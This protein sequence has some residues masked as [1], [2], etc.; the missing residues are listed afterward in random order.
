MTSP[1]R[2]NILVLCTGNSA[3]SIMAEALFGGAPGSPFRA[4]SAG[5]QPTGQPNPFAVEQ[6]KRHGLDLA[7][8]SKSWDEFV[9]A[10]APTLD[11]VVTV[12]DNAAAESCPVFPGG[13]QGISPL[14]IHWGLPDP[15]A[16]TGSDDDK[17][18]AFAIC[19]ATLQFRITHL[20]H[21][22]TPKMD[23]AGIRSLMQALGEN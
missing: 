15:A 5:S 11:F 8:R 21:E 14:K 19:F 9:G 22:I 1:D 12:C 7:P 18:R 23:R 10:D 3:R 2:Y 4:Y 13:P 20:I 16:V 6:I 17:R